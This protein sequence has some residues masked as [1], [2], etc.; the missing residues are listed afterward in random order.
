[1]TDPVSLTSFMD[2]VSKSGTPQYSQAKK[3]ATEL[4]EGYEFYADY[5]RLLRNPI[6]TMHRNGDPKSVLKNVLNGLNKKKVDNYT[7]AIS[8][9]SSFLG[10]SDTEGVV[11]K[12]SIWAGK[13]LQIRVNPEVLFAHKGTPTLCKL[14][15]KGTTLRKLD[16][17]VILHLLKHH[18]S[19]GK[20]HEVGVV[21]VQRGKIHLYSTTNYDPAVVEAI[22][23][24]NA[25]SLAT[26]ISTL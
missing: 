14:Y 3:I 15:F 24:A 23:S 8:G 16:T 11:P 9:Y 18:H 6:Q 25:A 5:W 22:L 20:T 13:D 12:S 4:A 26:M 2:F 10:R 17:V 7:K 1:M 21:D 19:A